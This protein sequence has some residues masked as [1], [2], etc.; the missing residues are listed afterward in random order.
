MDGIVDLKNNPEFSI[1][2]TIEMIEK[3]AEALT[4]VVEMVSDP[5]NIEPEKIVDAIIESDVISN[6]IQK[7][8]D[9]GVV[10]DPYQIADM[11]PQ[12]FTDQVQETL[13]DHGITKDNEVY[14]SL[15]ALISK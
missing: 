7:I 2:Q 9:N 13:D 6:T 10:T 15:M 5:E 1:D 4:Y 3:E 8:T 14:K 11:I 12:E